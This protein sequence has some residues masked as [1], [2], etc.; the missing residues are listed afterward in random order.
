MTA[1]VEAGM[2]LHK[3]IDRANIAFSQ[4]LN[5][6][7]LIES[8]RPG[9]QIHHVSASE[10]EEWSGARNHAQNP[11][12]QSKIEAELESRLTAAGLWY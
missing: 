8:Y 5:A 2:V 4:T 7:P 9:M 3:M 6:S 10:F 12:D 11:R 1:L